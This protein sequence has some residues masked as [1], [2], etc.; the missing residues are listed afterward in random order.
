MHTIT[1]MKF[2]TAPS[3]MVLHARILSGSGGGPDKTIMRSARYV[4]PARL[5]MGA[6]YIHPRHDPGIERIRQQAWGSDCRLWEVAERGPFDFRTLRSLIHLCRQQH[7]TIWHAHDYKTDVLGLLIR[8][9]WPMKLITTVHGFTRETWRTRLYYHVDNLVLRSYDHVIAVS[10]P[11]VKHCGRHG[12]TRERMTFIPN[13]IDPTEFQR[14]RTI[15]QARGELGLDENRLIL[16][17]VGRLSPE[18]GVDRAIRTLARLKRN[19]ENAELHLIGDG[20]QRAALT[21][22]VAKLALGDS[23][24]FWGWQQDTRCLYEMMNVLLLPSRTEGSP[25]AVLE[26]MSMRVPVAA[27]NV[28][29]VRDLLSW[30]SCGVILDEDELAWPNHIAPLLVSAE[31]RHELARRARLRIKQHFSFMK[32]MSKV[33]GIYEQMLHVRPAM[34]PSVRKLA[35]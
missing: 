35:A 24:R 28:G 27:T 15:K 19:H 5:R 14:H 10:P 26:A 21:K 12:V 3:P 16:G 2:P 33:M 31:R 17:V 18:K 32:R 6:V 20:P 34:R 1:D 22:L 25:N 8:R 29:G 7:V 9:F 13:A 30:G 4:D 11:L 23:V